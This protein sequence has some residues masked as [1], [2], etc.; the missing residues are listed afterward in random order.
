LTPLTA[1]DF[2]ERITTNDENLIVTYFVVEAHEAS[3][4]S[5]LKRGETALALV[6]CVDARVRAGS[7]YHVLWAQICIVAP[8]D[9][10]TEL[11]ESIAQCSR[12]LASVDLSVRAVWCSIRGPRDE[13]W[14]DEFLSELSAPHK[15][16]SVQF[17]QGRM[18]DGTVWSFSEGSAPPRH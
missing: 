12:G 17:V 11:V 6:R 3:S 16:G 13:R 18:V 2:V 9:R 10:S 1:F 4:A 15:F 8:I 5:R 7:A 14:I